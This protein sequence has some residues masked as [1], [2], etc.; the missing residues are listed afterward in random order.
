MQIRKGEK[1]DAAAIAEHLLLAME[2]IVYLFIGEE[3][4]DEAYRFISTL[5]EHEGNQYS[6]NNNWVVEVDGQVVATALLYD[7]AHLEQL[8]TP[9]ANLLREAYDLDFNPE[10]E[11]QAGEYYIDCIGVNPS[12]QGKGIG[13]KI[14]HFLID[15]YVEKQGITLGLLVDEINPNA[16]KL[17][18][19]I[20][21]EVVGEK[22]LLGKRLEHMQ[23]IPTHLK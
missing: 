9:V 8:R 4:Y 21:F 10:A 7:G 3:N 6:Y 18:E 16:K 13:T 23:K 11:T 19:R 17:Y 12:Q 22:T 1:K 14:L 2:D 15:E 5:V 20:G